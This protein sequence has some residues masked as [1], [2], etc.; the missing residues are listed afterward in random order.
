MDTHEIG[1]SGHKEMNFC[2]RLSFFVGLFMLACKTYAYVI[3]GS[4]AILSDAAESVVH[5]LAV[6]FATYSMWLSLKPADEDHLYGHEKISF[7]SAGFEGAAI[8]LAALFIYYESIPKI[9]SGEEVENIGLGIFFIIGATLI[10]LILSIFLIR[11]GKKHKS[12]ILEANG[13]HTLTDS[14][15]SFAAIMALVLVKL[16][17]IGLFDPIIAILAATNIL[18]TGGKLIKKSVTGLMDQI[19]PGIHKQIVEILHRETKEK[20]LQ[21]H[22]LRVRS[23]GH[24]ILIEFHLLFPEDLMLSSAHEIASQIEHSL[25][26]SLDM[27]SEILTHL[28]IKKSHD[29]THQKYGLPI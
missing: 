28:E 6:G 23:L 26:S 18:W 7:F 12:L 20:K 15:T 16:T 13:K 11:K 27:G 25:K 8:I 29:A 24:K 9:I 3:T 22:H 2:M 1:P 19:D 10:N 4:A 21:F 5:I 14:W 17:G